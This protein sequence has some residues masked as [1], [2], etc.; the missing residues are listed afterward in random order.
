MQKKEIQVVYII[1]KLELGGA[2][3]ICLSL[4]EGLPKQDIDTYLI[5]GDYGFFSD[6]VR[7][8]PSVCLLTSLQR[9]ISFFS[10]VNECK[11]FLELI[12]Q[13]KKLA[14][15]NPHLIVH[16]HSTKAGLIGRWAAFIAG[17][18]TRVHT[19]HGYSFHKYQSTITW[20]LIYLLELITS[21]ITSHYVCVST[22]DVKTGIRLF[23]G[24]KNKYSVIRAAV[25]WKNFE[26]PH[27][28]PLSFPLK[29]QSFIF[30]S[31]SCFKPQKNIIDL[32]KAFAVV[33]HINPQT[34]LEIIGD[35][36]QRVTIEKWIRQH[37][38]EQAVILHGWQE[39][40]QPL[41]ASWHTFT[42]SSLWE[43]LPCSIIEA[44]L[45]KMPILCYDTGG[46]KDVVIHG[47]N[48]FLYTPK[49]WQGLSE[50]MLELTMNKDLYSRF[51]KYQENLSDFQDSIM[52][53]QHANL[54]QK[55]AH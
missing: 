51:Q 43:G 18:H 1:T 39:Q 13:L 5:A 54:Y 10:L 55:L 26:V 31:I 40:V 19:V 3:K 8:L 33:H 24:F 52:L 22:A 49:N 4:L 14:K 11:A 44:R 28:K 46:I 21:F 48:G 7:H 41:L 6:K 16:T 17:I 12:A 42:L 9:E 50:G 47:C 36:I 27:F 25:N 30:G 37:E 45:L 34:Q 32:L 29:G 38:L 20:L 2:Q 15:N 35:G 23:P 53:A